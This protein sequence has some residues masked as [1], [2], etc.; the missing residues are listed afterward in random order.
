MVPRVDEVAPRTL[1]EDQTHLLAM[2]NLN[3]HSHRYA[4]WLISVDAGDRDDLAFQTGVSKSILTCPTIKD[5]KKFRHVRSFHEG[6]EFGVIPFHHEALTGINWASHRT[7]DAKAND[8]KVR[9]RVNQFE[10]W[11]HEKHGVD[12]E[13]LPAQ[14][15]PMPQEWYSHQIFKW[16]HKFLMVK[17]PGSCTGAGIDQAQFNNWDCWLCQMFEKFF[18]LLKRFQ[19]PTLELHFLI[20]NQH[21]MTEG[22]RK[23]LLASKATPG[24][25]R[26]KSR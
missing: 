12:I 8:S 18:P 5:D 4:T 2:T 10:Q 6:I 1:H 16:M 20:S 15:V 3:F 9:D 25:K 11:V 21:F 22:C 26:S 23:R 19:E 7:R 14:D 17:L 24:V 13:E